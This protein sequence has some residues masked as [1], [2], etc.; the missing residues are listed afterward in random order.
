MVRIGCI[1]LVLAYLIGIFW[2][3]LISIQDINEDYFL[4]EGVNFLKENTPGK[5]SPL[6]VESS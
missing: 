3:I 5:L 4:T 6:N 2:W 1:A